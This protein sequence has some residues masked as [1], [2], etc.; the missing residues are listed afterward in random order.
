DRTRA[1]TLGAWAGGG[2]QRRAAGGRDRARVALAALTEPA[3][4]RR[5]AYPKR[6]NTKSAGDRCRTLA[7]VRRLEAKLPERDG[8]ERYSCAHSR[9]RVSMVSREG[10]DHSTGARPSFPEKAV[11]LFDKAG[12]RRIAVHDEDVAAALQRDEA[13]SGNGRRE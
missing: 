6:E 1:A 12:E 11:H 13:R 4:I 3:A 10:V 7:E 2:Q 8:G 9:W 5:Q